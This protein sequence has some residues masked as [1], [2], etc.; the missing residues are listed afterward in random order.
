MGAGN[1]EDPPV[2]VVLMI[3]LQQMTS[4]LSED[5][6]SPHSVS[7]TSQSRLFGF[8][9]PQAEQRSYLS[10]CFL[11]CSLIVSKE[12]QSWDGT[13]ECGVTRSAQWK[14]TRS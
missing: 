11:P 4:E 1:V 5:D 12:Y 13:R 9:F 8:S 10:Q 6:V 3:R 14:V 2:A 7:V